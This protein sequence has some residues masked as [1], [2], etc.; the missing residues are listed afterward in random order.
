MTARALRETGTGRWRAWL[1]MAGVGAVVRRSGAALGFAREQRGS[2]GGIW[3]AH[4]AEWLHL[5]SLFVRVRIAF[6]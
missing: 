2:D 4:S 1:R 6:V 5:I 3:R